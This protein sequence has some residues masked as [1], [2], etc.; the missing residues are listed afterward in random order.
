MKSNYPD[1]RNKGILNKVENK[2]SPSDKKVYNQYLDFVSAKGCG[3]TKL[4]QY[5]NYFLQFIDILEKPL[6]KI[7]KS[8]VETFGSIVNKSN[9]A[10]PTKN[11]IKMTIKRFL[12]WY[13]KDTELLDCLKSCKVLVNREKINKST[14][15]T[16]RE[17]EAIFRTAD[18]FRDQCILSLF[19]E[20]A[21]RPEELRLLTFDRVSFENKTIT[22][23]SHKTKQSRTIPIE[24]SIDRLEIWKKNYSFP[25]VQPDDYIFPSPKDRTKPISQSFV[26]HLIKNLAKKAGIKRIITPYTY[27]HTKLTNLYNQGVGDLI[28]KKY[29]GHSP[30]SKM[31]SIYVAMD[32]EDMLDAVRKLYKQ[33][34]PP[35]KKGELEEKIERL[36]QENKK[37]AKGFVY[38]LN[39]L[40][41]IKKSKKR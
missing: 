3:E 41:N 38:I 33:D 34:L 12:K 28:H 15:L 8:D 9:K 35:E 40:K 23:Y 13:Y 21:G 6:N 14:L 24:N 20:S 7:K 2:L 26:T 4:I 19:E 25:N 27:R 36:W 1:Y 22:L 10:T 31:T 37:M 18:N 17:I 5:R 30:D 16:P 11:Q 32:D 39:E 29:A